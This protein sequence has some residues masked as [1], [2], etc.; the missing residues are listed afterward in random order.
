ML[1]CCG[2]VSVLFFKHSLTHIVG[3]SFFE[4]GCCFSSHR[5][6]SLVLVLALTLLRSC[7]L[8]LDADC[9]DFVFHF[10]GAQFGGRSLSVSLSL[11]E[12]YPRVVGGEYV[13]Q[14]LPLQAMHLII[15]VGAHLGPLQK[16]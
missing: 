10:V 9:W 6:F 3:C 4:G 1:S 13:P 14:R 16:A 8:P 15:P 12:V 11:A 7:S 2:P 5:A